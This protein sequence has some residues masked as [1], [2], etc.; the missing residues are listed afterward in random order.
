MAEPND[1]LEEAVE[2]LEANIQERLAEEGLVL[3]EGAG[4]KLEKDA[5]GFYLSGEKGTDNRTYWSLS[6]HKHSELV[7]MLAFSRLEGA[8]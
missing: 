3:P 7:V 1:V 2:E 5:E 6:L 8:T 4:V